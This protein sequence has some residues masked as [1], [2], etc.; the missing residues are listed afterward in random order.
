[1]E[2]KAKISRG[3]HSPLWM[4]LKEKAKDDP[5]LARMLDVAEE[6]MTR[7]SDTLQKLAD[8]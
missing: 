2:E 3:H 5:E 6:V 7:Y 8:S 1:M 4:E